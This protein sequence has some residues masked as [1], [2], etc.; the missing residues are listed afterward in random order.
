MAGHQDARGHLCAGRAGEGEARLLA[1]WRRR[2]HARGVGGGQQLLSALAAAGGEAAALFLSVP[3]APCFQNTE[4]L[5]DW[6]MMLPRPKDFYDPLDPSTFD[7]SVCVCWAD[8]VY[9]TT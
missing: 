3:R 5:L 7:S 9:V 8:N 4:R 1:G 6:A 2:R